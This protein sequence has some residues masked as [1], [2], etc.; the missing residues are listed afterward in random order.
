MQKFGFQLCTI[1]SDQT[2]LRG[3][4]RSELAAARAG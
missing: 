2:L 3:V 4:A 1:S